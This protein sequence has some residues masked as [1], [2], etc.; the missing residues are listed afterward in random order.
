MKKIS[1]FLII[2]ILSFINLKSNCYAMS[3]Y[4]II[5]QGGDVEMILRFEVSDSDS[6]WPIKNAIITLKDSRDIVS[7]YTNHEGIAVL[8]V[9][10][11]VG[12]ISGLDSIE[13]TAK[14]YSYF[15]K[16]VTQWDLLQQ[17]KNTHIH[18]PTSNWKMTDNMVIDALF[19]GS[20][21]PY[22]GNFITWENMVSVGYYF[23]EMAFSLEKTPHKIDIK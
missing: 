8:L 3:N 1:Y 5:G 23:I 22:D 12:Y 4:A 18:V 14:G 20:Y 2:F 7:L 15:E 16:D 9:K 17:Y 11:K 13:V 6:R 21:K 19:S 10:G